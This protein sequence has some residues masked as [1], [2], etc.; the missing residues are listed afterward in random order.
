MDKTTL[1][2]LALILVPL[3]VI[4]GLFIYFF[5][6]MQTNAVPAD[7]TAARQKA[8]AVSEDIVTLTGETGQKI[9]QANLIQNGGNVN[10]LLNLINGAKATNATAYQKA[11]DLSHTLQQMAESLNTVQQPRQ[12]L[13]YEAVALEL[14]LVSEFISYTGTLNDFLNNLSNAVIDQNPVSRKMAE[15][16]LKSV[17]QKADFINTLNKNFQDKMTAFDQAK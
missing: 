1:E 12:Q 13:G 8:A 14:S 2:R 5:S 17:N 15:D 11:F 4:I 6:S 9:S 10:E 3:L 7:F 16:S